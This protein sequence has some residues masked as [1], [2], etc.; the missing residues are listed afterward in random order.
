MKFDIPS[1]QLACEFCNSHMNPYDFTSEKG[2]EEQELYDVTIF[3]CPQCGGEILSTD[4]AATGFCSFCGASTILRSRIAKERRPG[5]I[6]PFTKTKEDC[7]KAYSDMMR[8]AF[9]APDELKNE[10]CIDSFRGIYMPYW[11]YYISQRGPL[12]IEGTKSHRKGDYVY[13][14]HYD[15]QAN[16]DCY[17]KGL[18]YDAS[19]SFADSISEAI[20]P[21][22]VKGM[23]AFTPAYLSGFYADTADVSPNLYQYDSMEYATDETYKNISTAP[24]FKSFTI[25]KPSSSTSPIHMQTKCETVDSAMFPV[26]FMSYRNGDRVAY[27]TVNGQTGK[28]V[29]DLPVD[30]KKYLIGSLIL[31]LPIFLLLNLFFTIKPTTLL[32]I[33][34]LLATITSILYAR[35]ISQI[36]RKDSG[37]DDKGQLAK[38]G[39][40]PNGN[41]KPSSKKKIQFTSNAKGA[42]WVFLIFFCAIWAMSLL[43][44]L[45]PG[46]L[47]TFVVI[48]SIAAGIIGSTK[49]KYLTC[50]KKVPG[51]IA[52]LAATGIAALI[53]LFHPVSDLYYY[54]GAI[55]VLVAMFF[56]ILDVMY[57]YNILA[58]RKLPQFD[59]TGG[60]DRA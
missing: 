35:E 2:A 34:A 43:V 38:Q 18:S 31:A 51:F 15:L 58:T 40:I 53:A 46:A 54:G 28:V 13:T 12:H 11:A 25:K 49:F 23:K 30:S 59:R 52:S 4:N 44:A 1:Q 48:G 3:T 47:W 55:L 24:V 10:K 20:A 57:Y 50:A 29:A 37:V 7:K 60:D 27:A 41:V 9:F 22:D 42:S 8:Y 16:L 14:D 26:W 32:C 45:G 39:G 56:T 6:I 5:Y 36:V 19:S 21:Y 17:Y 33:A